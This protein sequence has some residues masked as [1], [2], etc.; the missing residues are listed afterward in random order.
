MQ[1][2]TLVEKHNIEKLHFLVDSCE[3]VVGE[4]LACAHE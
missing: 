4:S 1:E 2:Q 3:K